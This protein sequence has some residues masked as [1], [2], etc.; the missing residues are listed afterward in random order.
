MHVKHSFIQNAFKKDFHQ[1]IFRT[2]VYKIKFDFL[3]SLSFD[4]DDD[5]DDDNDDDD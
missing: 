5:D 4:D 2:T 1:T 3:L